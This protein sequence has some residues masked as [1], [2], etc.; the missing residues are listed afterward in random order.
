MASCTSCDSSPSLHLPLL[1][2]SCLPP[3]PRWTSAQLPDPEYMEQQSPTDDSRHMREETER[4]IAK[5]AAEHGT[6]GPEILLNAVRKHTHTHTLGKYLSP[7]LVL[8]LSFSLSYE[9]PLSKECSHTT[10]FAHVASIEQG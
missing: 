3:P 10:L 9:H 1:N 7:S 4:A 6:Q 2:L 5:A 8:F